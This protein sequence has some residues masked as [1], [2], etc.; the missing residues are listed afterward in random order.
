MEFEWDKKK[1]KINQS[2]H[3]VSFHEVA[4]VFGDPLAMTFDDPEHSDVEERLLTFGTTRMGQLVIVSHTFINKKIR[5]I[6]AR[7]MDNNE[8]NFYEEG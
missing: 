1:D 8:R 6:S 3:K 5:I 7:M 4:S 2:N